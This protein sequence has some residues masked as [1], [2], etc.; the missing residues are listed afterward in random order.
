MADPE[1]DGYAL[2][3]VLAMLLVPAVPLSAFGVRRFRRAPER[4][5]PPFQ[6]RLRRGWDEATKS[7]S[8]LAHDSGLLVLPL[9]SFVLG[10]GG[11]LGAYLLTGAWAHRMMA[12]LAL[13][14]FITLLPFTLLG[15]FLGTAFIGALN[16]RLDGQHATAADGLRIAWQHR[17]PIFRWALL[18]AGVGAILQG[19]QQ[20]KSEWALAPLISAL[21]GIA[22]GVLTLFVLPVLAIEGVGVR[23]AA[24]RAG[25]LVREKWSEGMGGLGNLTT[26]SIVLTLPLAVAFGVVLGVTAVDHDAYTAVLVVFF[27]FM[28]ASSAVGTA[29]QVLAVALYR[30]ATGRSTGPFT[31]G[32]LNDALVRR[33]KLR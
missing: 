25:S 15:T 19:L 26:V 5:R 3:L 20:I 4:V 31:T 17:G 8:V 2:P 6:V 23:D 24:R 7:W 18:A 1:G 33:R 16:R 27:T 12:R 22:W 28:L 13:T 29:G 30:H 14:G 10:S 21:A 9:T 11:W 32:E